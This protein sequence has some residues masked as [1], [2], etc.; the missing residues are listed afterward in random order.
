[1]VDVKAKLSALPGVIP[2]IQ[3]YQVGQDLGVAEGNHDFS[4]VANFKSKAGL[5]TRGGPGVPPDPFAP[6]FQTPG[7]LSGL[8]KTQ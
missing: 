2:Q 8:A 7:T 5:I 1:V 4:I 3:S 6:P